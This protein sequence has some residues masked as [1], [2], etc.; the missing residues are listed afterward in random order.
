MAARLVWIAF[1]AACGGV[2]GGS[3]PK[4]PKHRGIEDA[5]LPY[6]ILDARS[7]HQI[8]T[9]AFWDKLAT[10]RAVCVG[11][12]HKNPHHHW[13]ELE[14]TRHLMKKWTHAALGMEMFQRPFQGVLDDYAA[15]RIDEGALRSR[16]GWEDRW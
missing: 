1:V 5:A 14:V 12:E 9:A 11:E 4:A 3:P 8:D 13:V 16:A 15:R 2:Y 10:E 7:G 6:Q